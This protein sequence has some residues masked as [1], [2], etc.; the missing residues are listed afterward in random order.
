MSGLALV[1][2][3]A[4]VDQLDGGVALVELPDGRLVTVARRALP[5]RAA[6]GTRLCVAP[7]PESEPPSYTFTRAR[8]AQ[9]GEKHD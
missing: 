3:L 9:L 6:E 4:V 1:C 2:A 7:T 5:R 8:R